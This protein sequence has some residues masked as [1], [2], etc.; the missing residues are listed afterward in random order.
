MG[1]DNLSL[2]T[3][4]RTEIIKEL[5]MVLDISGR[6]C[7]FTIVRTTC[8]LLFNI[9]CHTDLSR[10]LCGGYPT[11]CEKQ[12]R[13]E[14]GVGGAEDRWLD[15]SQETAETCWLPEHTSQA[16]RAQGH[17]QSLRTNGNLKHANNNKKKFTILYVTMKTIKI[18]V[19]LN[20]NWR[21]A[22]T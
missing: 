18:A 7:V 15:R 20:R 9:C 21:V 17:E 13:V 16:A 6:Y 8:C 3:T 5:S 19:V 1:H 10:R 11:P 4:Q 12:G 14:A 2:T 22:Q